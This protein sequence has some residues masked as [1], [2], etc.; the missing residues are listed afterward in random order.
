R[1]GARHLGRGAGVRVRA[2]PAARPRP[3]EHSDRRV[4]VG[5]AI[6]VR[7]TGT[8]AGRVGV[9]EVDALSGGGVGFVAQFRGYL[10]YL[11]FVCGRSWGVAARLR[12]TRSWAR[13]CGGRTGSA[14]AGVTVPWW[15]PPLRCF[16]S[17]PVPRANPFCCTR[18]CTGTTW[19]G[20]SG[21]PG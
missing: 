21:C 13:R 17:W 12:S 3:A 20:R 1:R 4:P 2:V 14:R 19:Y 16:A 10:D 6:L 9:F 5:R 11:C 18:I 8:G 15:T 7:R